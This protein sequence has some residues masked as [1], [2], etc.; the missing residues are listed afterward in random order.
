MSPDSSTFGK[1]G[2]AL[3]KITCLV[4][5]DGHPVNPARMAE[6]AMQGVHGFVWDA[7]IGDRAEADLIVVADQKVNGRVR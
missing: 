3:V 5:D 6:H 4:K 7:C 2:F 1:R